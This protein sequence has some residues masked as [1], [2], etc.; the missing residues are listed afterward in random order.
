MLAPSPARDQRVGIGAGLLAAI[1]WGMA[2]V[3]TKGTLGH[4]EPLPLV[5]L[6]LTGSNAVLWPML[7]L[8]RTA[9]IRG[10]EL[11]SLG[12]PGLIQPGL[13]FVLGTIGLALTTASNDALIWASESVMVIGLAWLL[14]GRRPAPKLVLLAAAALAGVALATSNPTGQ[15]TP[16][17]LAGNALI[18]AA[19][20]CGAYYTLVT[21]RQLRQ[22]HPLALLALHQLWGFGCAVV[23]WLA[24]VAFTGRNGFPPQLSAYWLVAFGS[25]MLQ[26]ALPFLLFLVALDRLGASRVSSFLTVPPV[27]TIVGARIFLGEHL[28]GVQL[29]GGVVVLVAVVAIQRIAPE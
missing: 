4:F 20:A 14:F 10:G 12:W 1:L 19:V 23:V 9:P 2:N 8:S 22:R 21:E 28:A 16:I 13:A 7:L 25:G 6:Q 24:T 27:V 15:G 3:L 26:F 17:S 18:L 29:L 11:R 5:L